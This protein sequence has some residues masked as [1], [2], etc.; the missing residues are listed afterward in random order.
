MFSRHF[1][2]SGSDRIQASG[3]TTSGILLVLAFLLTACGQVSLSAEEHIERGASFEAKADLQAASIEYRNALQRDPTSAE[4]RVRLGKL[5]LT[6]RDGAG[7]QV[8]LRRALDLGWNADE[9]VVPMA[10]AMW[11][12]DR[13]E[14]VVKATIDTDRLP[15][16]AI[17]EALALRGLARLAKGER[18]D[19]RTDF[20]QAL[21]TAPRQRDALLGLAQLEASAGE[22]GPARDWLQ[23]L[24]ST[25]PDA[26]QAWELLGDLEQEAGNLDDALAAYDKAIEF[27][28]QPL[29]P[30]LKRIL[31]RVT[32]ADLDGAKRDIAALP[33]NAGTH[34]GTHYA[35]GLIR[36]HEGEYDE[37]RTLFEEALARHGNYRPAMLMLGSAHF[38]L[39]NEQQA[40]H[41]LRRYLNFVPDSAPAI[42]QL[43]RLYA[44][45]GR[46]AEARRLLDDAA[47]QWN[48][49]HPRLMALESQLAFARGDADR[50]LA[51][52]T[53]L[54]AAEPD[55]P[56][57]HEMRGAELIRQGD[58]AGGIAAL[59]QAAALDSTARRADLV[60]ILSEL[61]AGN[62]ELALAAAR[63]LQEKQPD[64]AEPW[65]LIGG[66]LMGLGRVEEARE[67]F[68]E[69]AAVEPS[70]VSTGMNLG[71]LE[72]MFEQ[73][74]AAR[75]AFAA[76]QRH[77]PGHVPSAQRLAELA[78]RSGDP[79]D[80]IR[81]LR[82]ST[83]AQPEVIIPHL[84]LARIHLD[85]GRVEQA[86][87]ALEQAREHHPTDREVLYA[88][89]H[90]YVEAN[91][92]ADAV[93]VLE[94][95]VA[96]SP[97]DLDLNLA[98]ARV[99]LAAGDLDAH[100]LT[101]RKALDLEPSHYGARVALARS[102][103]QRGEWEALQLQ[104]DE[105]RAS[106][107]Q[108]AEVQAL[109]G[110]SAL[111]RGNAE[112]AVSAYE[113]AV[114]E[115]PGER[116]WITALA[117]AQWQA[118][119]RE[120]SQATL[121]RWLEAN[122]GD[123]ANWHVFAGRQL[124]AGQPD[125]ALASYQRILTRNPDDP[126]ALNNAAW[127]IKD[128]DSLKAL[129][130]A[131][132][133]HGLEPSQPNI[134]HTLGVVLLSQGERERALELLTHAAELDPN[135]PDFQYNLA[136]AQAEMGDPAASKATLS[137]LLDRGEGFPEREAAE[138]L[139][140]NLATER[141]D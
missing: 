3:I 33:R 75:E 128:E 99:Q 27:S 1:L 18:N 43:A 98:L 81:W 72:L 64:R 88:L 8:E 58:R 110:Q 116:R 96:Y 5:L 37:A 9:L 135:A 85:L 138:T 46:L 60:I 89:S 113:K 57:W 32:M 68:R 139:L 10:R 100:E 70:H 103:A 105:L 12:Q 19:A 120:Q 90:V 66:A 22:I 42:E 48:G 140:H 63:A 126:I 38:R 122:P 7:A 130:Y 53:S 107:P 134:L 83:T 118:N 13:H 101:L 136:R 20:Q 129:E 55:S 59:R 17:P 82:E 54:A 104:L 97:D 65:N 45:T 69:G 44:V 87:N 23:M 21:L 95:A 15:E 56:D 47:R 25:D 115:N 117:S 71:N 2:G 28:H 124:E 4:A 6:V 73:N 74:D 137:R 36:F 125:A 114:R 30:R 108:R 111:A 93:S 50:G 80:A 133:A 41:F 40:E 76:I 29:S 84:M 67:A 26:D 35:R 79:E 91:Q 131:E 119:A 112:E 127:L 92:V 86:R 132:R 78:L 51:L 24:L 61:E 121:R 14:D 141:L 52:L 94:N 123:L 34:P 106:H 16:A 31:L 39:A 49:T 77:H 11:L 62:Y 102:L 109:I